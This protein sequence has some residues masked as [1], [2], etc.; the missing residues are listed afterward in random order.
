[1]LE[2]K[3]QTLY[4]SHSPSSY[5]LLSAVLFGWLLTMQPQK[6]QSDSITP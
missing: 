2:N 1:M 4:H 3:D 5:V 6:S